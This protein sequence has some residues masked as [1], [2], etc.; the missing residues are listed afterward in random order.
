MGAFRAL[1]WCAGCDIGRACYAW[2][3]AIWAA[4]LRHCLA[5]LSPAGQGIVYEALDMSQLP[6]YTV[7]GTIHLVV[8]NQ[9]SQTD[10]GCCEGLMCRCGQMHPPP[11]G[12]PPGKYSWIDSWCCS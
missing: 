8:N 2:Q 6:E 12:Q 3:E 4:K 10:I 1:A 5:L 11:G 7:G 9:A